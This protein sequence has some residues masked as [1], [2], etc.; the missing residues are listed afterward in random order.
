MAAYPRQESLGDSVVLDH[1]E[2]EM[3]YQVYP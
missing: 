1:E 3:G 2:V